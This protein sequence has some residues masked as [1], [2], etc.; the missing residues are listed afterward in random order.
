MA[1]AD[2]QGAQAQHTHRSSTTLRKQLHTAVSGYGAQD[3]QPL[4]PYTALAAIFNVLFAG[5]LL[6][7]KR[8][9]HSLPE[10]LAPRDILLLGVATHKLSRLISRDQ[11]TAFL[12]APFVTYKSPA[13]AS[14]VE[15]EPRGTG[16]QRALGN[17][18]TCPY[19]VAQWVAAGFVSGLLV[20]PRATRLVASTFAVYTLAEF[21]GL[22]YEKAVKIAQ[23]PSGGQRQAQRE[24]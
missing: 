1:H 24:C 15:E 19:C 18:L 20:A 3:I 6:A 14:E 22:A 5:I 17:L 7:V 13:A 10:H 8:T 9:N 23:P 12:R 21:L 2:T 4:A 11:V 16:W